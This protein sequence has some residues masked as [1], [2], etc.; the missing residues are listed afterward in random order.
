MEALSM[1]NVEVAPA[2][3][4]GRYRLL[5]EIGVGGMATVYRGHDERLGRHVAVKVMKPDLASNPTLRARFVQEARTMARLDVHP[6]VVQIYDFGQDDD[7]QRL[8]IAMELLGRSLQHLLDRHG[9]L[10][11]RLASELMVQVLEALEIAH[12]HHV[13]HRDVKPS[14]ILLTREGTTKVSD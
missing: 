11:P 3:A 9:R 13:V 14:N 6:H 4:R 12:R 10:P 7:D 2:L 5:E 8:Y 1:S